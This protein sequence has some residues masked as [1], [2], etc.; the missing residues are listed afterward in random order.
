MVV[1]VADADSGHHLAAS[2]REH[3]K[4]E[5]RKWR[6]ITNRAWVLHHL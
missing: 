2:F 5:A 4:G 6:P 3:L 1:D